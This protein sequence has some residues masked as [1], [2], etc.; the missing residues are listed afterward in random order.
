MAGV[1]TIRP[2]NLSNIT[3]QIAGDDIS[4]NY[5]LDPNSVEL[6]ATERMAQQSRP[7]LFS[8]PF[9]FKLWVFGDTQAGTITN[10]K[11]VV[12]AMTNPDGG[13]IEYR[14][15]GLSTGVLTTYY[16]YC[17]RAGEHPEL[18]DPVAFD[19]AKMA[20]LGYR[21]GG[22]KYGMVLNIE[23]STRPYGTSNPT[24]LATLK[25]A[26]SID[27]AH[28]ATYDNTLTILDGAIKGVGAMPV[29]MISPDAA[30]N[31]DRLLLHRK[32]L[33]AGS[34]LS[35]R[36]DVWEVE[37]MQVE[38]GSW[39]AVADGNASDGDYRRTNS[40]AGILLAT[41]FN[42]YSGLAPRP[43][44]GKI[45]PILVN[46]WSDNGSSYRARFRMASGLTGSIVVYSNWV[47][48]PARTTGEEFVLYTFTELD[49]PPSPWPPEW[50]ADASWGARFSNT[51]LK[52]EVDQISGSGYV[53]LDWLFVASSH[54]FISVFEAG[55]GADLVTGS[56]M[57]IDPFNQAAYTENASGNYYRHDHWFKYGSP[58][59]RMIMG[60][61][62]D[63]RLRFVFWRD[64]DDTYVRTA[65][66]TITI[67]GLHLTIFPFETS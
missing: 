66:H 42:H 63:H 16:H 24:S 19:E 31:C 26:T 51:V 5:V 48:V 34:A 67:Y 7:G 18:D 29:L 59:E 41:P 36:F 61:G 21:G 35:T 32:T 4:V 1:F 45:T 50:V 30:T 62:Y 13:F 54:D 3:C 47:T 49:F 64:A 55:S 53:N 25:T 15:R 38:G 37:D 44:F 17:A 43:F 56:R 58:Y 9:G 10:A 14:P 8:C 65:A 33:P 28:D 23:V 20:Q 60:K 22:Q 52:L 12:V 11:T 6:H 27:N 57:W 40:A 46:C 39:G 2:H